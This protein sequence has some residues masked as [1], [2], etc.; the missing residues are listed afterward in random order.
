MAKPGKSHK[1]ASYT[2]AW[3][4]LLTVAAFFPGIKKD[5]AGAS[6]NALEVA[7]IVQAVI[8]G[9]SSMWLLARP[10]SSR[11]AGI[12]T[13]SLIIFASEILYGILIARLWVDPGYAVIA[14]V[15]LVPLLILDSIGIVCGVRSYR[16]KT[17][18]VNETEDKVSNV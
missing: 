11:A 9:A 8:L 6:V 5:L 4:R 2:A 12:V 18:I 10:A 17:G 14:L 7:F 16:F 15:P 1:A 13:L 3:V